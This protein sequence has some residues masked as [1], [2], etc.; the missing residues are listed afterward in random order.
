MK[1]QCSSQLVQKAINSMGCNLLMPKYCGTHLKISQPS[2]HAVFY[3]LIYLRD[4][5]YAAQ[6][7]VEA[8][9]IGG[10]FACL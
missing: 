8:L 5:K 6:I 9:R 4:R 3:R 2:D 7:A 1:V 10:N